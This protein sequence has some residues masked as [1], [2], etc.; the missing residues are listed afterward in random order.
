[1]T[2]WLQLLVRGSQ[3]TPTSQPDS[4]NPLST[5]PLE[6]RD[7][8]IHTAERIAILRGHELHLTSEEFDVLLFLATHPRGLVTQRTILTTASSVGKLRQTEFLRSLVSLRSK[9]NATGTEGPNLRTEV[10]VMYRLDSNSS[11]PTRGAQ[12]E[13]YWGNT[14]A[15]ICGRFRKKGL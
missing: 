3:T 14:V 5:E 15:K 7:L 10:W 8:T 11:V 2:K 9:L 6:C 1:M 12:S 4:E 13:T